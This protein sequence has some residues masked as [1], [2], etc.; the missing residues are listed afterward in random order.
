M[1]SKV[2]LITGGSRGL[3][4]SIALRLAEAGVNVLITYR[5]DEEL[6][7]GVVGELEGAG[8]KA[9]KLHLDVTDFDGYAEFADRV[10]HALRENFGQSHLD[11]LV[12]NAGVLVYAPYAVAEQHDFDQMFSVNVKAPYFL[13]KALLETFENGSRVLNV[14]TAVARAVVPGLSAYAASKGAVEV[15][16]RYLAAE[17]AGRGIRVNTL[18][19]G[20]IDTELGSGI[21]RTDEVRALAAQQI[22]L[23]R[24]GTADE[25]AAAV[26]AIL[27]DAFAWATGAAI[28]FSGGQSL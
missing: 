15:L 13:T 8:V 22:A 16:T 18:V 4:R 7:K 9:E 12:N 21:L 23:G 26:P 6:A 28:E 27:S 10:R 5:S 19:G 14:S 11:Y 1:D 24:M 2:A 3:G 25:L 17:L 20:A